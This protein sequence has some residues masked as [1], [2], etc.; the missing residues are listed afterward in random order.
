[1]RF[2]PPDGKRIAAA[3]AVF[4]AASL[5]LN[6]A[7]LVGLTPILADY[8]WYRD[9]RAWVS[10]NLLQRETADV[11]AIYQT[12]S[13]TLQPSARFEPTYTLAG[14]LQHGYDAEQ[15]RQDASRAMWQGRMERG[16]FDLEEG[17]V[18]EE[19]RF[20]R[21]R[22]S[23]VTQPGVRIPAY[24]LEPK[25]PPPWPAV[26]VVHGCGYGKAG[27]AGVIEDQHRSIGVE[28]AN[29]GFLVL[30]PDRRGFGELQPVPHYIAPDCTGG[31]R[32]GRT[33]LNRDAFTRY[34][35]DL[36]SLDVFDL[37]V[38]AEYLSSREDV[39]A[40]GIAGL[41]G[42]GVVAQYVAGMSDDIEAV[43]LSNSMSI[44]EALYSQALEGADPPPASPAFNE[45]PR[46]P[47][48]WAA[49]RRTEVFSALG[50]IMDSVALVPLVML[51]PK[52]VLV[53]YGDSDDVNY[54]R[55][56]QNAIELVKTIYEARGL[57][58][59]VEVSIEPGG[60]EFFPGPVIA[61]FKMR[62]G[63]S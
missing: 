42:G 4:L 33:M 13:Y 17:E 9:A 58:D 44:S 25:T 35:V 36:R 1:M 15:M 22:I 2:P 30:V 6:A 18:E 10:K 46:T 24:L 52:A 57:G 14:L 62:L 8:V 7:L 19:D 20:L 34:H 41:S 55:G 54:L 12:S 53:Q 5:A 51:P 60:H 29:A 38:A 40:L 26:L 3:L 45:M 23:Y 27:P 31:L 43:V 50:T 16:P 48:E 11:A 61:F 47:G 39:T 21:I 32:D 59:L 37:L 63:A 49:W 28:L 56:G